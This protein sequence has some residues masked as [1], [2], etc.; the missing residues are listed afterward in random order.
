MVHQKRIQHL[1]K[2]L[3]AADLDALILNPGPSLKYL[4]GLSFHLMERPVLAI[5]KL[6]QSPHLIVPELER[7]KAETIEFEAEILT[8]G[9]D[10]ASRTQA[11]S[12]A[13]ARLSLDGGRLGVEPLRMRV[14]ELRLLESSAP[15]ASFVSA[16]QILA[17]V[18][19]LKDDHEIESMRRAVE[20]AEKALKGL[21]TLLHPG[22]TEREAEAELVLQL[23]QAGSDSE[24]PFSPIVASGPNSAMPHAT[25]TER[26][27]QS[28]DLLILDWGARAQGY[29][30]D[31]T[32]TFAIGEIDPELTKIH[33]IVQEANAAGREAVR[34]GVPCAEID[35][36]CRT[37]IEKAG[38]GPYFIHRTGHGIGLEAHEQ[39]YIHAN[40]AQTLSM[41]MT[42]TIEPG[43]YLPG[44]GGVRIEDNVVVTPDGYTSLTTFPRKL[45][46]VA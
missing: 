46:M 30:S 38:Y 18:R 19:L 2:N 31:I 29:I 25:P 13:A 7:S 26:P 9:E 11:L 42:F 32:R 36:A 27:L 10:I 8:Y 37:V 17:D 16:E 43:I 1:L 39:P 44:R 21:L 24:L 5:F 6:G 35:Q 14:F 45:E 22:M 34:C 23:L 12:D 41:G 40:N 33:T 3:E 28:G 20:I 15:T 4:T